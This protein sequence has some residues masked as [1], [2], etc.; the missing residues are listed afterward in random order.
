MMDDSRRFAE[1]PLA[2]ERAP[3]AR[4]SAGVPAAAANVN[5]PSRIAA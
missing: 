3:A 1:A 2:G 5:Y 4:R